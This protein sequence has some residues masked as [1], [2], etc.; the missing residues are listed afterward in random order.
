MENLVSIIEIHLLPYFYDFSTLTS[1]WQ[2]LLHGILCAV[3]FYIVVYVFLLV[4]FKFLKR[5]IN[6][7]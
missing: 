6:L 7:K 5:F 1:D 3:C 2:E 4:P